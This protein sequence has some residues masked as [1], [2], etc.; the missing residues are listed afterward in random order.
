MDL[1]IMKGTISFAIVGWCLLLLSLVDIDQRGM[2]GIHTSLKIK[3]E[4][5]HLKKPLPYQSD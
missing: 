2:A 1:M 5:F 4:V 3:K